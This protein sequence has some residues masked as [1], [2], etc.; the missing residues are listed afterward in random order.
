LS[1]FEKL[2]TNGFQGEPNDKIAPQ[3]SQRDEREHR[4]AAI[5]ASGVHIQTNAGH[6]H[7]AA[8]QQRRQ[9]EDE[10]PPTPPPARTGPRGYYAEEEQED[11]VEQRV[12]RELQLLRDT[13]SNSV[14]PSTNDYID[15]LFQQAQHAY[16]L[17]TLTSRGIEDQE[18]RSY[19]FNV[20]QAV[21]ES[22]LT[23]RTTAAAVL[24][25]SDNNE[26]LLAAIIQ[27]AQYNLAAGVVPT[28]SN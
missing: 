7:Q 24:A 6:P 20:V 17:L 12:R 18:T 14:Q 1:L 3:Q 4:A 13:V 27:L 28:N 11:G 15:Q 22:L 2:T 23:A 9:D 19:M 25:M 5:Y 16:D 10:E 8:F 21:G 26:R